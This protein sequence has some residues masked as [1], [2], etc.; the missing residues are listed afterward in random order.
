MDPK[1]PRIKHVH[2]EGADI[3]PTGKP[4]GASIP[5]E[6]A[7]HPEVIVAY[8]MNDEEIPRDHGHPLRLI[9]PGK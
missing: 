4:Y 6:K 8:K 3:D 7:M 5:F 2:L 1:D 9:A